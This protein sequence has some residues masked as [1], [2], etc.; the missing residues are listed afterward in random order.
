VDELKIDRSFVMGMEDDHRDAAIVQA[1][2]DLGLRLGLRVVAEGVETPTARRRLADLRCDV[3]QG[4][5][6]ARPLPEAQLRAWVAR[7][8]AVAL[9]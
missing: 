5:V 8:A 2:V 3:L 4:Y 9:A 1:A 7:R 6:V